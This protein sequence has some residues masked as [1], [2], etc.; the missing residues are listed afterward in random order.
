MHTNTNKVFWVKL[1]YDTPI[2]KLFDIAKD[3][4][5]ISMQRDDANSYY[6]EFQ[7]IYEHKYNI[8][9]V[10]EVFREK[11]GPDCLVTD[12]DSAEKYSKV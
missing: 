5:D 6:I 7:S 9:D 10:M 12:F 3:L 8:K 1:D 11:L 2:Q 4:G